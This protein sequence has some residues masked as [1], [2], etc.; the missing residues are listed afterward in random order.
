MR[1]L[2]YHK[3]VNM[4]KAKPRTVFPFPVWGAPTICWCSWYSCVWESPVVQWEKGGQGVQGFLKLPTSWAKLLCVNGIALAEEKKLQPQEMSVTLTRSRER[5]NKWMEV[6]VQV[7]A[8]ISRAS[9]LSL[10]RGGPAPTAT[11]SPWA[12]KMLLDPGFCPLRWM[13]ACFSLIPGSV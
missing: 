12:P 11:P 8:C 9:V 5:R 1:C 7:L 6:C 4:I 10:E 13:G 2:H 3:L